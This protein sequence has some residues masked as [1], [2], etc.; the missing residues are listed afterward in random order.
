M[1]TRPGLILTLSI[2]A[3]LAPLAARAQETP[4]RHT[5]YIAPGN[6][7]TVG[8]NGSVEGV[9]PGQA[10]PAPH[11]A[12]ATFGGLLGTGAPRAAATPGTAPVTAP[13]AAAR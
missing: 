6:P 7:A 10:V 11:G 5:F 13:P 8:R 3:S 12:M 2:A 4:R 1:K 9:V